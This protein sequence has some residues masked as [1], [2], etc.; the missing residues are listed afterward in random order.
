[1]K[2]KEY[3]LLDKLKAVGPG[4]VVTASFIGPG[5][6]TMAS[7]AGASFGYSLLWTL[8]FSIIMTI[9]LQEMAAR[10][11]I[12][13]GEGLGNAILKSIKN[14]TLRTVSAYLI[15]GSILLGSL[16]YIAGDL[17]GTSLGVEQLVNLPMQVI[18]LIVGI[19]VLFL[20]GLDSMKILENFLTF[21]VAVMAVVFITTMFVAKP[22]L[23]E[24][25]QGLIPQFPENSNLIIISLIGTT[26]VPYNFFIHAGNAH[27]NFNKDELELSKFDT[28]FSLS[29]GGLITAVVLITAGTLMRGMP[30]TSAADLSVQL[31][32]LLGEW[33]AIFMAIGLISAGLSSAIA[34]PLGASYT[35]AGL[36]GWEATNADKRFKWT[37]IAVVIFGIFINTLGIEP[38]VI[39]QVAQA[40]NGIIL[41]I[42]A[43]Y[44]VYVTSNAEIMGDYKNSRWQ[45]I[46]G[47]LV[48]LVTVVLGAN[49]IWSVFVG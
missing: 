31:E 49:A 25:A 17:S 38:M 14:P 33:A 47:A 12:V 2:T 1:M 26:V 41:P 6:I 7:Q 23:G 48:C 22:D 18:G 8:V 29:I 34:S 37:N 21:L 3:T 5:T 19:I 32:P 43:I 10:L 46:L 4:A 16:S 36:F 15:G 42:V 28:V 39:I 11:G 9:I 27:Q 35:L 30:I 24:L 40:L 44:L 45:T 20:V 13:T